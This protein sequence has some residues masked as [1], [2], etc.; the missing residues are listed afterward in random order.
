ME[1]ARAASTAQRAPPPSGL[2]LAEDK[3]NPMRP[4]GRTR[5]RTRLNGGVQERVNTMC[6]S[7]EGSAYDAPREGTVRLRCA[8]RPYPAASRATPRRSGRADTK[9]DSKEQIDLVRRAASVPR[10]LFGRRAPRR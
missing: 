3:A 10:R 5:P 6:A 9:L 1:I 7:E 8:A 4:G 2:R